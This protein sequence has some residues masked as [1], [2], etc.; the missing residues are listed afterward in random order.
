MGDESR[1]SLK[2]FGRIGEPGIFY[3]LISL[4]I[5]FFYLLPFYLLGTHAPV[6][7]WDNLD[8]NLIWFKV[9][10]GSGKIFGSFQDT[11]PAIMNGLPRNNL[12][13]EFSVI[14]WLHY[15]SPPYLAYILNLT[16]MHLVAFFGMY[17]L[18]KDHIIKEEKYLIIISGT[19]LA[20][21]LLPFW[22]YG[23]L[24]I[25]GQPLVLWAFLNIRAGLSSARGWVVLFL[26]PF[27]SYFYY[28]YVFFLTIMGILFLYDTV[29]RR[30]PNYPFL[31]AILFM[32]AISLLVEYR[33]FYDYFFN[34]DYVS[35]RTEWNASPYSTSPVNSVNNA[36]RFLTLENSNGHSLH[37]YFIGLALLV[38]LLP[39]GLK[40]KGD[41]RSISLIIVLVAGSSLALMDNST[42]FLLLLLISLVYLA[43]LFVS[44]GYRVV[45][46]PDSFLSL[47]IVPVGLEN[48]YLITYLLNNAPISIFGG[49]VYLLPLA[50][51]IALFLLIGYF[52]RTR[53]GENLVLGMVFLII[54]FLNNYILRYIKSTIPAFAGFYAQILLFSVWFI[55]IALFFQT[56]LRGFQLSTVA[57]LSHRNDGRLLSYCLFAILGIIAFAGFWTWEGLVP[58][59][60]Q[61]MVLK[62]FQ[63]DRFYWLCPLLWYIIFGLALKIVWDTVRSGKKFA[64]LILFL[65][66]LFLFSFLPGIG[67]LESQAQT[68][69]IGLLLDSQPSFQEYYK[70]GIMN[71]IKA[72][73]GRPQEEYRVV[74][75]YLNPSVAQYN[76]FFTLDFYL[77]NYPLQYKHQF[78]AIIAKELEKNRFTREYFN[79]WGSRCYIFTVSDPVDLNITALK[80]LHGEYILSDRPVLLTEQDRISLLKTFGDSGSGDKIWLYQVV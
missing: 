43:W 29:R 51:L 12:G 40:K 23:G 49:F 68:G 1:F 48:A 80:S 17:L 56:A 75:M 60:N 70:E 63:F 69:G 14:L 38:A 42:I 19:A 54:I 41:E 64:V 10:A 26:V 28:S 16:G 71:E 24:S 22:P 6:M 52:Y 35:F 79:Y 5:L 50:A 4:T 66:C 62:I 3:L 36:I 9:L 34:H 65:Q 2:L 78:R 25:A 58:I 55:V 33:L 45:S 67:Y 59:K 57:P 30:K 11:I 20:F 47:F 44:T 27:W 21:A 32:A 61:V 8:S 7:A 46:G 18:L 74:S 72:Y 39:L 76:G 53:Q 15:F 73:I 13:S 77:N 31:K 37:Q